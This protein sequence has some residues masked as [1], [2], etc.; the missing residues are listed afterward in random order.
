MDSFEVKW[1]ADDGYAGGSRPQHFNIDSNV[2]DDSMTESDLRQMF[3]EELEQEFANKVHA[4]TQDEDAFVRW[5]QAK[6]EILKEENAAEF[7]N[8]QE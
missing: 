5:A 2:L 6:I 3:Q 7:S 1:Q 8:Y 4:V